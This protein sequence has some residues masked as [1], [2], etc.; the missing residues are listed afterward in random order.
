[1]IGNSK[2]ARLIESKHWKHGDRIVCICKPEDQP[3]LVLNTYYHVSTV[4]EGRVCLKEFPCHVFSVSIFSRLI[5]DC[6]IGE[7]FCRNCDPEVNPLKKKADQKSVADDWNIGDHFVWNG[8]TNDCITKGKTY[9]VIDYQ[10][11]NVTFKNNLGHNGLLFQSEMKMNAV[12]TSLPPNTVYGF[13]AKPDAVLVGFS[14]GFDND[15]GSMERVKKAAEDAG[16]KVTS[17]K[18]PYQLAI[19]QPVEEKKPDTRTADQKLA[20]DIL[21]QETAIDHGI[22]AV[23]DAI[24]ELSRIDK[25]IALDIQAVHCKAEI[26][27][28]VKIINQRRGDRGS[29]LPRKLNQPMMGDF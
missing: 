13:A 2:G 18:N 4:N 20:D 21:K 27:K 12:K 22:S 8:S 16:A 15:N 10:N 1:M 5:C 19:N 23:V 29:G 7:E 9:T 3:N 6:K 28:V 26:D 24:L 11:R 14:S 17:V 25:R